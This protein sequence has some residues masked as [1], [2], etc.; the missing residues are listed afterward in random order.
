MN[1]F[2]GAHMDMNILILLSAC[3]T[4]ALTAMTVAIAGTARARREAQEAKARL[5]L[6]DSRLANLEAAMNL[7]SLNIQGLSDRLQQLAVLQQ[8]VDAPASRPAL[9]EAIALTRNGA[10]PEQIVRHC[11]IGEG[12]ARL[13]QALHGPGALPVDMH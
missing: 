1:A 13:I 2:E 3:A 11:G 7:S 9:R 5:V 10:R 12:E 8:R 6:A 4:V